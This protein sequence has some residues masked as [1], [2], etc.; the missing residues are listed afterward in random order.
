[1]ILEKMKF[2][3]GLK[4]QI[5]KYF[6]KVRSIYEITGLWGKN[7]FLVKSKIECYTVLA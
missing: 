7:K 5:I 4:I 3:I 1:M 2:F 6:K